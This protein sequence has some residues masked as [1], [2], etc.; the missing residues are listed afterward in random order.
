M[1]GAAASGSTAKVAWLH[2]VRG[3]PLPVDIS[4]FAA[5][6]ANIQRLVLLEEMHA[7]F[8]EHTV[9]AAAATGSM[10]MVEYLCDQG[11]RLGLGATNAAARRG[12][13]NMLK[14]L[15][16][17]D[18]PWHTSGIDRFVA[19]SG[20][21]NLLQCIKEEGCELTAAVADVAAEKGDLAML[22]FAWKEQ[23]EFETDVCT[24]AALHGHLPVLMWAVE[25]GVPIDYHDV[26]ETA[27]SNGSVQILQFAQEQFHQLS[28]DQK[29]EL[30][31]IAGLNG[32]IEAA[33]WLKEHGAAWPEILAY[34]DRC[35]RSSALAW[36]VEQGCT[37]MKWCSFRRCTLPNTS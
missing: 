12:D 11:C 28:D 19:E 31:S 14:Y 3:C 34:K 9:A 10:E 29:T 26:I 21:V 25:N 20:D 24:T 7:V 30:L 35:W 5:T 36:A 33:S 15:R 13:L 1:L 23:C 27:A 22:A 6:S 37:S 18:C 16:S 4:H 8:D 2:R 32:E 17:R